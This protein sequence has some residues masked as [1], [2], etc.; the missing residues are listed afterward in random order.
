MWVSLKISHLLACIIRLSCAILITAHIAAKV[1][2]TVNSCNVNLPC[3]SLGFSLSPAEGINTKRKGYSHFQSVSVGLNVITQ[4]CLYVVGA[5]KHCKLFE[6]ILTSSDPRGLKRKSLEEDKLCEEGS[7]LAWMDLEVLVEAWTKG[8][9]EMS[10]I[11]IL[12]LSFLKIPVLMPLPSV[13]EQSSGRPS[14]QERERVKEKFGVPQR[15]VYLLFPAL[16][17]LYLI[18]TVFLS[19]LGL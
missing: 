7:R 18:Q 10:E 13:W 4:W 1:K 8:C 6:M 15:Y 9:I 16:I 17:R 11:I 14:M 19:L 12:L 3:H 2:T 5:L